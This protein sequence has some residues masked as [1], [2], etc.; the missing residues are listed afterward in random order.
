MEI[1]QN[2]SVEDVKNVTK[3]LFYDNKIPNME[4]V[5]QEGSGFDVN[6]EDAKYW[7]D[8]VTN[9]DEEEQEVLNKI[10]EYNQ[11]KNL[12]S[13]YIYRRGTAYKRW[14]QQ[15]YDIEDLKITSTNTGIK[16]EVLYKGR[17]LCAMALP[18]KDRFDDLKSFEIQTI[19]KSGGYLSS[20]ETVGFYTKNH[21]RFMNKPKTMDEKQEKAYDLIKNRVNNKVPEI[22]EKNRY[23]YEL[24]NRF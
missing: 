21:E 3:E 22:F 23:S 20:P 4:L 16:V 19:S 17:T 12:L 5:D 11:M 8:K 7:L 15:Q 13:E 6:E 14:G 18:K 2:T 24:R 9:S 1:K 10:S